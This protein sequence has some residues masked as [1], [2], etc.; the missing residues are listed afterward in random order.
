MLHEDYRFGAPDHA[1]GQY[2]KRTLCYVFW[3]RACGYSYSFISA[4]LGLE[5]SSKSSIWSVVQGVKSEPD[6]L[7]E[8]DFLWPIDFVVGN[9]KRTEFFCRYC[10]LKYGAA[11]DAIGHAYRHVFGHLPSESE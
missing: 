1:P 10:G 9:R 6:T 8:C 5:P 2:S 4:K 3:L 7:I 11:V